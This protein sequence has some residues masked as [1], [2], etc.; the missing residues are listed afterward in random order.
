MKHNSKKLNLCVTNYQWAVENSEYP[1]GTLTASNKNVHYFS[2]CRIVFCSGICLVQWG[3][4]TSYQRAL[5]GFSCLSQCASL[6]HSSLLCSPGL[7]HGW[8]CWSVT[9]WLP[10][11][12]A[13]NA[14]E[15]WHCCQSWL[16]ATLSREVR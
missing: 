15:A 14:R 5:Y 16:L 13:Q 11:L 4:G 1:F 2:R 3:E 7:H 10:P 12:P 8:E 6:P 9:G